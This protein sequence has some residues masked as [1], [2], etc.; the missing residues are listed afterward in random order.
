MRKIEIYRGGLSV[1]S[2]DNLPAQAELFAD[3]V[4]TYAERAAARQAIKA[5]RAALLKEIKPRAATLLAAAEARIV[6]IYPA[7]GAGSA[8]QA[9]DEAARCE[10]RRQARR[11]LAT[12]KK[13]AREL[14][15]VGAQILLDSELA[16][17]GLTISMACTLPARLPASIEAI[18][19]EIVL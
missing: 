15:V 8:Q 19:P 4:M 10:L 1:V 13:H 17:V 2:R 14:I 7:N 18:M 16:N 6:D 12:V 3:R 5:R 11:Q 9:A